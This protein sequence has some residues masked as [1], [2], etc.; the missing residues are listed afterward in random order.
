VQQAG[1]HLQ[2]GGLAGPVR[3]EEPDDLATSHLHVDPVD[4]SDVAVPPVHEA[5]HRRFQARLADRHPEHLAQVAHLDRE[6]AGRHA[7]RP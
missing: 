5:H 1:Q 7:E 6:L 3:P 4:R 2:R